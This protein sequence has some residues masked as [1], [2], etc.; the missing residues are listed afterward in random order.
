MLWSVIVVKISYELQK[1]PTL[2]KSGDFA[3]NF[4]VQSSFVATL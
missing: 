1:R 4:T 2:N 3:L